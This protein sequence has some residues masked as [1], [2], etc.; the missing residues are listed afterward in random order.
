[1]DFEWDP[2]KSAATYRARGFDFAYACRIFTTD[3]M[4]AV[5]ARADYGET[6]MKAI[7]QTGADILVVVYTVRGTALRIISA[8][9]ANRKERAQW[10]SRA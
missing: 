9:R 5:D 10:Q 1:V 6:R 2:A 7:G 3:W 4:A 8:R